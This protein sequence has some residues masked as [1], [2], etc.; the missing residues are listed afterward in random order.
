MKA[1][2]RIAALAATVLAGMVGTG[3]TVMAATTHASNPQVNRCCWD[4]RDHRGNFDR[5]EWRGRD[6][7][8]SRSGWSWEQQCDWAYYN[9]RGWW[10]RNCS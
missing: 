1:R 7:D 6:W 10:W 8:H 2:Y 5:R 3:G 9:D 4:R